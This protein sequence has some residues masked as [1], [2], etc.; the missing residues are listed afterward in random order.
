MSLW[1]LVALAIEPCHVY[2][3]EGR[4]YGLSLA[5]VIP[6][7]SSIRRALASLEARGLVE[8]ASTQSGKASGNARRL[9]GLTES[10]W[11]DLET[12]RRRLGYELRALDTALV[13]RLIA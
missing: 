1:V 5:E 13:Q 9:Y 8:V 6:A 2:G 4:I 10:G 7:R 12:E 11:R 3:I